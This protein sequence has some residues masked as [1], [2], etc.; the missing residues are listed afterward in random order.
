M[1]QMVRS[2]CLAVILGGALGCGG[3][4]YYLVKDPSTGKTYYSDKVDKDKGGAVTLTDSRTKSTVTIQNSEVTEISK[5]T[6][7][8]GVAAPAPAAAP[9]AAATPASTPPAPTATPPAP[10]TTPAPAK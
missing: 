6:Y 1:K 2:G 8:Q 10:A 7:E 3:A 4:N 5:Q 9:D